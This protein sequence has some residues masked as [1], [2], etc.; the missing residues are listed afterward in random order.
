MLPKTEEIAAMDALEQ[1]RPA[2]LRRLWRACSR[3]WQNWQWPVVA[4]LFVAGLALG[5]IGYA[6][7]FSQ[8]PGFSHSLLDSL[9]HSLQLTVLEF[10]AFDRPLHWTLHVARFLLPVVA[11]YT[12]IKAVGALYSEQLQ[13]LR[14]RLFAHDHVVICG[15]GQRGLKLTRA[16]VARG[17]RVVVVE[18]DA[19]NDDIRA[20]R[21]SGAAVLVGDATRQDVLRRAR[22][23]RARSLV[24]VC[25]SDGLN[26]EIAVQAQRVGRSRGDRL[27]CHCH[28]DGFRLRRL[29]ENSRALMPATN[30]EQVRFFSIYEK[31]A[32]VLLGLEPP[33]DGVPAGASPHFLILGVGRMGESLLVRLAERWKEKRGDTVVKLRVTILDRLA[34]GKR[35]FLISEH[36]ELDGV[37]ELNPVQVELK[38]PEFLTGRFLSE[39]GW[40][41]VRRV[42]VCFDDDGAGLSAALIVEA[43]LKKRGRMIPIVLR[44]REGH[45]LAVLVPKAGCHDCP[46]DG[47]RAFPLLEQTCKP[48]VILG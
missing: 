39:A 32:E 36:P 48:E 11:A 23:D 37:W 31:G 46:R 44:T 1:R 33:F 42:Y 6:R 30:M 10:N 9:Y 24:A 20:A 14:V 38:E 19:E 7:Y 3:W 29:I 41:D 35:D 45:G 12:A 40:H 13:N 43:Q 25:P 28:V 47:L 5:T 21:D 22:V 8:I 27:H 18:Q 26:A 34:L 15:L 17:E 16:F 4:V 2:T